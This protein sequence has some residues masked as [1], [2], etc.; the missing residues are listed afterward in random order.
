MV[1][2]ITLT[3]IT[4]IPPMTL[5][6]N[7]NTPSTNSPTI[8]QRKNKIINAIKGYLINFGTFLSELTES[9][10]SNIS[11]NNNSNIKSIILSHVKNSIIFLYKFT[12]RIIRTSIKNSI[13]SLSL[14]KRHTAKRTYI[15]LLYITNIMFYNI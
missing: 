4:N 7:E 9:A 5:F 13:L 3:N 11:S 2:S 10:P 1:K 15:I 6:F 14:N 12:I 8:T